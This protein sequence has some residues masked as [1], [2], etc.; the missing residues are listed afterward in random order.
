MFQ[1]SV[2]DNGIRVVTE[3]IPH[4]YS[5]S[6]GFWFRVGSAYE[7]AEYSGASHFIEH[8]LFKGTANRSAREIA[9][10]IDS[11]GGEVNAF[12]GREYTC[13]YARVFRKHLPIA[14]DLL[15][16]MLLNPCFDE[17]ELQKERGVIIQEI[18]MYKDTP[19]ELVHELLVNYL[20]EGHGLG[21]SILGTEESV[22]AFDSDRLQRF[23]EDN[24]TPANL[25][26]GVAGNV[27]HGEVVQLLEEYFS[28]WTT[29]HQKTELTKPGYH[30][31]MAYKEKDLEQL[32]LC[33]AVPGLTRY[34][35]LRYPMYVLDTVLG[36]GNSSRLFQKLREEQGLAYSTYSF[37]SSYAHA[38]LFGVYAGIDADS[39]EQTLELIQEE[40]HQLMKHP[41]SQL[42]LDRAKEQ[43]KGNLMLGLEST[44]ARMGRL[45][46]S[47]LFDK[48]V[49]TPLQICQRIDDVTI[50]DVYQVSSLLFSR[51]VSV[52]AVG[53]NAAGIREFFDQ[54]AIIAC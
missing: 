50:E 34:S 49:S 11:T 47:I 40:I 6:I 46:K 53:R 4:V 18:K 21:Q 1:Y 39:L 17:G 7:P 32:H 19:E 22:R 36:G 5:V 42:E 38:G 43:L 30:H 29:K 52:V 2:L 9:E 16:D 8:M 26:V 27:E 54:A 23:K 37:H 45:S 41:I 20:F 44:A 24:Y 15:T 3:T 48:P 28:Q 10:L 14:I 31:F 12:T 51:P 13:Y 33:L 25:V 35:S